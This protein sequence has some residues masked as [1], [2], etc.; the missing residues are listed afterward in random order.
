MSQ[1]TNDV[2]YFG[3]GVEMYKDD[4]VASHTGAW[5]SGVKDARFG[6]IMPGRVLLNASYYQEV[7]PQVAMDRAKIVS[8]SETIKTPAGEFTNCLKVEET[9]PLEPFVREF[10]YYAPGIGMVQDGL[11]KLVKVG[12]AD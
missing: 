6:L 9:T 12:K 1:R 7:A 3:E 5:L 2:F 10:K 4:K 11:L 8:T